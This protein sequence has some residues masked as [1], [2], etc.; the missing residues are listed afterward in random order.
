MKYGNNVEVDETFIG[1]KEPNKHASKKQHASR[2]TVGKIAVIGAVERQ[3]NIKAAVIENTDS[4]ILKKFIDENIEKDFNIYTDSFKGYKNLNG[5]KHDSVKHSVGEYV[6]GK[7]HTN[8]IESF[9]ATL[10]RGYY[11]IYHTMSFAH[12]QRYVNK[13]VYRYNQEGSI[14]DSVNNTIVRGIGNRLTYKRLI[15]G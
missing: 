11:G 5:Y 15:N 1:G 6:K 2:G 14:I 10:K 12:L 13:F 3:G 4:K 8:G 7:A 9:W